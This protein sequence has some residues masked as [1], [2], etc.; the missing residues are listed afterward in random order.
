MVA[1]FQFSAMVFYVAYAIYVLAKW[2]KYQVNCANADFDFGCRYG[3]FGV[4]GILHLWGAIFCSIL[5]WNFGLYAP[6]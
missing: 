3:I 6:K 2:Q 4:F 5:S 1:Y